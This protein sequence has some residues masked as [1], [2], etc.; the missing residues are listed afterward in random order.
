M[1][2]FKGLACLGAAIAAVWRGNAYT[3]NHP[4]I[5]APVMCM[6]FAISVA[7]TVLAMTIP[8]GEG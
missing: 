4:G 2:G 1:N 6:L 7:M 5:T 8:P 3:S